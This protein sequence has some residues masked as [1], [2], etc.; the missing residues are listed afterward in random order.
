MNT[1]AVC[2]VIG[3]A[4]VMIV[5]AAIGAGGWQLW[6]GGA[7][8]W[9]DIVA[10]EATV[11]RTSIGM[12]VIALLLVVAGGA[13]IGNV[14]WGGGAA[15]IATLLVVMAAFFVNQALFGSARALHM[16]TNLVVALIVLA[17]LWF[18]YSRPPSD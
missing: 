1:A 16:G 15:A 17:L 18:G 4:I 13:A 2:R 8:K 10:D 11:Q 12:M 14:A 3:G 9:P 7:A 6:Q 5:A